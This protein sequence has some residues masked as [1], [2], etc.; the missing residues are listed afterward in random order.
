MDHTIPKLIGYSEGPELTEPEPNREK[1]ISFECDTF[2]KEEK[3]IQFW[4]QCE[5]WGEVMY[6]PRSLSLNDF[7]REVF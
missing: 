1:K 5:H 4:S 3:E 7:Q 6:A 2:S